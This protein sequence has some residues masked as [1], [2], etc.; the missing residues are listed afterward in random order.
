MPVIRVSEFTVKDRQT[1]PPNATAVA[2]VKW[3]PTMFTLAPVAPSEGSKLVMV[4]AG[5]ELSSI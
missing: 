2:P 4:G 3:V 1:T 5:V